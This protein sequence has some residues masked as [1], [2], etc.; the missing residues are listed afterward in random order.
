M[1]IKNLSRAAEINAYLPAIDEARKAI[2][3]GKASVR[4]VTSAGK[5]I[6]LPE[7]LNYNFVHVLNCEYERLR[8]EV[9][10]L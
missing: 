9:K 10:K 8:E 5:I 1:D 4:I 3:G 2:S 6:S 7:N